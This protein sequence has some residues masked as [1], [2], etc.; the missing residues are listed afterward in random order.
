MYYR[1]TMSEGKTLVLMFIRFSIAYCPAPVINI[2]CPVNLCS[3]SKVNNKNFVRNQNVPVSILCV[4]LNR[5]SARRA[6][7]NLNCRLVFGQFVSLE[8]VYIYTYNAWWYVYNLY[9]N[10]V[11]TI[12][13]NTALR[14]LYKGEF[15]LRWL[16]RSALATHTSLA[17]RLL[18]HSCVVNSL[19][20]P[21]KVLACVEGMS[22]IICFHSGFSS[23]LWPNKQ[24][25]KGGDDP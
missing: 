15:W 12:F 9:V 24:K 19:V 13:V 10:T 6:M 18:G 7:D 3:S 1:S 23:V 16:Q 20:L 4:L 8:A 21:L 2:V 5:W 14:A 11:D 25:G 17:T 22:M